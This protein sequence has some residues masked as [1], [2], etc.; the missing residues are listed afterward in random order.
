M[1][2]KEWENHCRE[3][4]ARISA[5]SR[6]RAGS[7]LPCV[8]ERTEWEKFQQVMRESW[9]SFEN[10]L[11]LYPHTLLTL[12]ASLAFHEYEDNTFWTQ[13]CRAV[14]VAHLPANRQTAIN[15]GFAHAAR[16]A[17]LPIIE[18]T[19]HRSFVG[20]AV[21][22]IGVPVSVWDGFLGICDWALWHSGWD[23]VSDEKWV[24][25]MVKR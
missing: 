12:Y 19:G 22:F 23:E 5:D 11:H 25:V 9:W 14:G 21:Y 18:Q 8:P 6:S 20:S 17:G 3:K 16:F 24:E 1:H 4:I 7:L 13:F 15:D 2:L 10:C